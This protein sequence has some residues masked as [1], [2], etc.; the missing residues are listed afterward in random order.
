MEDKAPVIQG[1][2]VRGGRQAERRPDCYSLSALRENRNSMARKK[3]HIRPRIA[4][5]KT[6]SGLPRPHSLRYSEDTPAQSNPLM[7]KIAVSVLIALI[8][9]LLNNIELPF[10]Q[11]LVGHVRNA[12]TQ[13]FDLDDTLGKLKFVGEVLPDEIRAVFGQGQDMLFV[14]PVQGRVINTFGKKIDLEDAGISYTNQGIDIETLEN[15]PFFAAADGMVAAVEEHKVFGKS[16][17]LDHND[18]IFSFYGRCGEISVKKGE[19]VRRGQKLGTVMTPSDGTPVLHFQI[20]MN[21]K[22]QDP[23]DL[24]GRADKEGEDRGV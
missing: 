23:L 14:S 7:I 13:E 11:A 18:R 1:R 10:A 12:L 21:D 20:W 5:R 9:L 15:A 16:L 22:P 8:I 17:W 19:K 2:S 3:P 4:R 6:D 24:I